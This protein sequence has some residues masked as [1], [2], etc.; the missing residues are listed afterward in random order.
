MDHRPPPDLRRPRRAIRQHRRLSPFKTYPIYAPGH[1]PPGYLNSLQQQDPQILWDDAGHRPPLET[2]SDWI[3]AGEMVFDA[4]A[5]F[6][7][8]RAVATTEDV[9]NPKCSATAA[10][11]PRSKTGSTPAACGTITLPQALSL[12]EQKPTP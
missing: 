3:K 4:P 1:E 11:A 7:G 8:V 10:G 2:E 6:Q 12:T 9:R 5:G